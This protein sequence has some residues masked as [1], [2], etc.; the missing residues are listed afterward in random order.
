M[1]SYT[2]DESPV[3]KKV[4]GAF[5]VAALVLCLALTGCGLISIGISNS[6]DWCSNPRSTVPC[7]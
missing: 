5:R 7:P 2:I 6:P 3:T 4:A 1:M